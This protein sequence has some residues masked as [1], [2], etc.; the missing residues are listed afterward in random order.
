MLRL[1]LGEVY[2]RV[3][4]HVRS[5]IIV[6]WVLLN[7]CELVIFLLSFLVFSLHQLG[8]LGFLLLFSLSLLPFK[9]F[10]FF[11]FEALGLLSCFL[12]FLSLGLAT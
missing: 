8:T 7:F 2:G 4:L 6:V 10:S 1:N 12:L 9:A 5:T 3:V 11:S